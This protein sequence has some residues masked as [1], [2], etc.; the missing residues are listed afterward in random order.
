MWASWQHALVAAAGGLAL[1]S[2]RRCVPPMNGVRMKVS[3]GGVNIA[4]PLVRGRV[5][6]GE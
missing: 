2:S 3:L 5:R 4:H 6:S 1:K